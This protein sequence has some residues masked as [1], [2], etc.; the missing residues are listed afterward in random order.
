MRP[1]LAKYEVAIE[2]PVKFSEIDFPR[3]ET[4]LLL[5]EL[6]DCY[7]AVILVLDAR[8]D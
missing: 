1:V 6:C 4:I 5:I 8:D 3:D 2:E 7:P